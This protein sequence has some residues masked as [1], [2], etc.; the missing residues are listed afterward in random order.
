MPKRD[1]VTLPS[2]QA[3]VWSGAA[4]VPWPSDRDRQRAFEFS[5]RAAIELG[6]GLAEGDGPDWPR[7]VA[8][9]EVVETY[10]WL[11]VAMGTAR[12]TPGGR[13][14]ADL[15]RRGYALAARASVGRQR[16]TAR[17]LDWTGALWFGIGLPRRDGR[18]W[19]C[20]EQ[21]AVQIDIAA[22][23]EL[24]FVSAHVT[25]RI[26]FKLRREGHHLDLD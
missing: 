3:P 2:G 11:L 13:A 5:R 19:V 26:K 12:G 16:P 1:H 24:R 22:L 8:D 10:R 4:A 7:C 6:K 9:P 14:I 15:A 23:P 18:R 21:D 25:V 17:A 20:M